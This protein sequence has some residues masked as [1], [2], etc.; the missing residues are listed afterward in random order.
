MRLPI[1]SLSVSLLDVAER[2][3]PRGFRFTKG[4]PRCVLL[5]MRSQ[6]RAEIRRDD[7][8]G[9]AASIT[10]QAKAKAALVLAVVIAAVITPL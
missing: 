2:V 3:Q 5:A 8:E 7:P 10:L 4:F 6:V 9:F 1:R